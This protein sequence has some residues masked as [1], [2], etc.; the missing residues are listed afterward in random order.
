MASY[1]FMKILESAPQRY[2]M[3]INLIS[4]G[5]DR[6]MQ[7]EIVEEYVHKSNQ[8]LEIG[9]GTG[10]LAISCAKKG[11][12]VVAFDISRQMLAIAERKVREH[13]LIEKIQLK[14]MG[15]IEMEK[16]F[17]ENTFDRI[18]STLVFS[19]LYDYEQ[20]YVLNQAYRVLRPNGL[21]IIA[22]EVKP[23][24]L[25]KRIVHSSIRIPLALITYLLTQTSTKALGDIKGPITNA[26]F[27]IIH[28]KR[29]FIDS[30]T[31]FVGQKE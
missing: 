17:N 1:I 29:S 4:F 9:C 12:S 26:G 18:V 27:K 14:E 20:K 13:N 15:A 5:Q 19:E 21:I 30:F 11:A 10:T 3:G 6:R 24:S 25:W 8:V 28:E 31:L 7:Q 2:D 22:D 23:R 16:A